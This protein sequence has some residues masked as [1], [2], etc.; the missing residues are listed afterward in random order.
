MLHTAMRRED[1][2]W[3]LPSRR[4]SF[5]GVTLF[6]AKLPVGFVGDN[7]HTTVH[8]MTTAPMPTKSLVLR[9]GGSFLG[10]PKEALFGE[11]TP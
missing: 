1:R 8:R 9:E 3:S 4:L 5:V 6:R 10:A 7:G 11:T 2:R